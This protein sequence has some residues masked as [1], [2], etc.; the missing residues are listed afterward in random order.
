MFEA[1]IGWLA[2]FAIVAVLAALG[3][4]AEEWGADTRDDFASA[5]DRSAVSLTNVHPDPW[6]LGRCPRRSPFV[7]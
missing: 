3:L 7:A 6:T 5:V 1:G 2:L 4:L